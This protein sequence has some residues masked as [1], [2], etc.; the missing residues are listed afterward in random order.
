MVTTFGMSPWH[1]DTT[2]TGIGVCEV[3]ELVLYIGRVG[4]ATN[5]EEEAVSVCV[6]VRE[7]ERESKIVYVRNVSIKE[8]VMLFGAW[9]R[10]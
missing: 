4:M 3:H 9:R 1:R 5:G 8:F 10:Q 6:C 2:L 7:R